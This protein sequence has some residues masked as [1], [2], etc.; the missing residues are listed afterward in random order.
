MDC[1]SLFI[2]SL[3]FGVAAGVAVDGREVQSV[4]AKEG[5]SGPTV[6]SWIVRARS[7]EPLGL[8]VAAGVAVDPAR[9]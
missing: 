2:K 4:V 7:I 5:C 6:F 3:G 9:L 8:G 1:P